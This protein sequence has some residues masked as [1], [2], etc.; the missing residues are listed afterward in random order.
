MRHVAK[1]ITLCHV[2]R[3]VIVNALG[4]EMQLCQVMT[5]E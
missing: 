5:I 3:H 4:K 2:T 1:Y